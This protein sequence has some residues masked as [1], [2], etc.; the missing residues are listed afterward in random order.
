MTGPDQPFDLRCK[1]STG[2][3]GRYSGSSVSATSTRSARLE[4]RLDVDRRSSADSPVMNKVSGDR[5]TRTLRPF[6]PGF[7]AEVCSWPAT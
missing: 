7:G 3:S 1:R 4:L 2:I 5:F 6:P